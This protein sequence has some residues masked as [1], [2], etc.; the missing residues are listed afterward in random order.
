MDRLIH[1]ALSSLRGAM[2]RQSVTANNLANVATPGFRAEVSSAQARWVNGP[3]YQARAVALQGVMGADMGAGT[4]A[5][6]GRDMDIA[7]VG[8]A[9]LTVQDGDGNEAYTRRGDLQLSPSGLL[10]TGDGHPVMGDQGPITVPPADSMRIDADGSLWVVPRGGDPDAPQR[11][12][13]LKLASPGGSQIEKGLDT[14]FHVPGGGVLPS[15]P[16]ARLATG[17]LEQSNVNATQ[18]LVAMIEAA[19]GYETQM[20]LISTA[21]N[22]DQAGA[23]LMRLPE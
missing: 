3:G 23:D 15:D 6:T 1:T 16:A 9:L 4:V 22:L 21:Q 11:I 19:R 18:A 14:L 17:Q 7:I 8:D 13:R 2:A 10:T 20:R 5:Q 12:D